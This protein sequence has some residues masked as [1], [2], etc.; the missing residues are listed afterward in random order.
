MSTAD[1]VEIMLFEEASDNVAAK[2]E[3]DT[4]LVLSPSINILIRVRPEKIAE[5]TSIWDISWTHNVSDLVHRM[6]IGRKTTMHTK[7][8]FIDNS[9]NRETIEAIGK[10]FP[11]LDG[12]PPLAFI[13]ETVN[14]VDAGTLVVS[15][16]DEKVFRIFDLVSE[17]EGNGLQ[18][19]TATI[20]IVSQEEIV[21]LRGE[22]AV[23]KEPQKIIILTMNISCINL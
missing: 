14:S 23:L 15:A 16:E 5:E 13:V 3:R 19:L 21:G 2:G 10:E 17:E 18:R 11:E 1:K 12:E 20:D 22:T 4:T 8:L 9:S 6:E 7:D